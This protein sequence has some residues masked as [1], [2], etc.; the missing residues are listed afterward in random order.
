VAQQVCLLIHGFSGGPHEVEPLA[1]H[2][3]REGY[4]TRVAILPGHGPDRA[5]LG[6]VRWREWVDEACAEAAKLQEEAGMFDLVGF[7]MGGLIAAYLANRYSV[8][9]LVLLNAAVYYL[10][11]TRF[12]RDLAERLSRRDLL[13]LSRISSTPLQAVRQFMQL[14][15]NLK[16]EFGSISVPTLIVQGQ[17]DPVVHPRSANYLYSAIPG[18]KAVR[19]YPQARHLICLEPGAELVFRDVSR[20]LACRD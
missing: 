8:R 18:E 10:S 13:V 17:Q 4:R 20:F 3:E 11:P 12:V 5:N 19:L 7:S 1:R 14:V 2:L 9:R 16:P 15:R 6:K